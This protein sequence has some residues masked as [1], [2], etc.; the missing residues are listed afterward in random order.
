MQECPFPC[1]LK[2]IPVGWR[3]EDLDVY[4]ACHCPIQSAKTLTKVRTIKSGWCLQVLLTVICESGYKALRQ[5]NA[6]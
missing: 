4:T 5:F 6:T 3:D 2:D 1:I